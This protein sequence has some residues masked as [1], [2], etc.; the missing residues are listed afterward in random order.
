MRIKNTDPILKEG[1]GEC[2]TI[3]VMHADP[4]LSGT[5]NVQEFRAGPEMHNNVQ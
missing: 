5:M 4:D 2:L 3:G 1:G